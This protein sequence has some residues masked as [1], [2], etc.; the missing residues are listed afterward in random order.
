VGL[1]TGGRRAKSLKNRVESSK[2]ELQFRGVRLEGS[3]PRAAVLPEII[4]HNQKS[5]YSSGF[6]PVYRLFRMF[7]MAK[8]Q[9]KINR[10]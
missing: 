3:S 6:S 7:K 10:G 4:T 5:L 1:R 9:Q 8:N 2:I